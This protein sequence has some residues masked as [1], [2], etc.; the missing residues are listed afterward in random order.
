M[1]F[2][3]KSKVQNEWDDMV[4]KM[5]LLLSYINMR[6]T[7]P[8]NDIP[9]LRHIFF[10]RSHNAPSSQCS[11]YSADKSTWED[12][13]ADNHPQCCFLTFNYKKISC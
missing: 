9:S 12:L 6:Q 7:C 8:D 2:F 13:T 4:Y 5:T 11:E 1:V 10:Y 3:S